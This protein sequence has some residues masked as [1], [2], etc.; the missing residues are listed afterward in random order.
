MKN[1]IKIGANALKWIVA[2]RTKRIISG[3]IALG[4][5]GAVSATV[6]VNAQTGRR[7]NVQVCKAA[8]SYT[9]SE[10]YSVPPITSS[11]TTSTTS[12]V[13]SQAQAA[14]SQA[15][16][17]A[18]P[19]AS[20]NSKNDSGNKASTTNGKDTT[21]T[22]TNPNYSH[23]TTK[24]QHT[25]PQATQNVPKQTQQNQGQQ[26]T[27]AA[28]QGGG[29]TTGLSPNE[30][31][32]AD[33]I[34]ASITKYYADKG[35]TFVGDKVFHENGDPYIVCS[36]TLSGKGQ[37]HKVELDVNYGSSGYYVVDGVKVS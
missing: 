28:P 35:Y 23:V 10:D 5:V 19:A 24:E 21:K 8:S 16:A 34:I 22:T 29:T 3:A 4:L 7:K 30:P 9:D 14:S 17:A 18:A 32:K 6:L 25:N 11:S 15:S 37:A 1:I 2:T 31:Y 26:T 13:S 27:P 33:D 36:G 20:Q 12:T